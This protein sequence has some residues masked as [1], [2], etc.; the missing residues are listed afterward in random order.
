MLAGLLLWFFVLGFS[1]INPGG[2]D[3]RER[4]K[5]KKQR[6]DWGYLTLLPAVPSWLTNRCASRSCL[7]LHWTV[8]HF[9][10]LV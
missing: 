6:I 2:R 1:F 5:R 9:K 7:I 4:G 3:L 10:K 8:L